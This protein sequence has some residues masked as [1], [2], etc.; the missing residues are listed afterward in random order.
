[1]KPKAKRSAKLPTKAGGGKNGRRGIRPVQFNQSV[2]DRIC[3]EVAGG[4]NLNRI[5]KHDW[6]PIRRIVYKWLR[7]NKDFEN[8]YARARE[9]RADWRADRIDYYKRLVL[10][11]QLDPQAAR[12]IIDTEKWQAGKEKPKVY[13]D[14]IDLNHAGNVA[15]AV[16]KIETVIVDPLNETSNGAHENETAS[17]GRKQQSAK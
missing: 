4:S 9:D 3:D 5:T 10:K 6:A 1:M 11:G 13:G 2:A 15:V 16:S 7:E 14:K 8:K 12:V 17:P